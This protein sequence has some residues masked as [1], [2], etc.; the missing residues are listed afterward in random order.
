MVIQF[1]SKKSKYGLSKKYLPKYGYSLYLP[2]KQ[3]SGDGIGDIFNWLST[4]SG[5]IKD[6]TTAGTNT[7]QSL[8]KTAVDT[9]KGIN[10][11]KILRASL[12]NAERLVKPVTSTILRLAPS[13]LTE[14]AQDKILAS[15]PDRKTGN[16]FKIIR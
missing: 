1:Y 11:I 16:G 15:I 6:L 9:A 12:A 3:Y 14:S 4:N 10:E 5:V 13:P 7:L 8:S 2:R